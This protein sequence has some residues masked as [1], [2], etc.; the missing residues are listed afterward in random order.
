MRQG[1]NT[2]RD[3]VYGLH[4]FLK[5]NYACNVC[6]NTSVVES[7]CC[8]AHSRVY[9]RISVLWEEC[10]CPKGEFDQW[11][12]LE[13]VMGTC[14]QCGID[15]L[16]LCPAEILGLE[17]YK[18]KWKCFQY[19]EVGRTA[20]GRP[21]KR[22]KE[23]FMET[24]PSVFIEYMKPKVHQFIKHNFVASWQDEA[25]KEMMVNMPAGVL[26]SHIDFA[27]NYTFQIQNE[28]QS[29]YFFLKVSRYWST[30]HCIGDCPVPAVKKVTSSNTLITIY[31]MTKSMTL[32]LCSIA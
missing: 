32:F 4:A 6:T 11:H 21:R 30:L 24:S 25:C 8:N 2:L 3:L 5:C 31:Q 9:K 19:E 12:K 1:L 7:T 23:T 29:M 13:C 17:E 22:I 27:E 28:I 14:G 15:K 26:V 10:V 18:L 20:E 16:S